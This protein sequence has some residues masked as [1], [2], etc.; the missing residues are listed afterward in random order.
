MIVDDEQLSRSIVNHFIE[1]TN[2]LKL[3]HECKDAIEALN[4]LQE[5][6]SD[7]DLIYLDIQMPEMS[8]MDFMRSLEN[9]IDV[10]I[11]TSG[12]QYAVEAFESSVIDYLVKPFDYGRF[13]RASNKVR[14]RIESLNLRN[15]RRS[16]IYVKSDSKTVRI[17]FKDIFYIEALADYVIFVTIKGKFIVHYTMKGIEQRLPASI[18]SRVHRSFIINKDRIESIED[19]N[20]IMGD[21]AIP[22]G[23]SYRD[24]FISQLNFL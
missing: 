15:E 5:K 21:K 1:K 16:D 10:I 9:P 6:N 24:A 17:M 20:I 13:L 2:F 4:I 3:Q 7:I 18:F 12:E 23:A 11:T 14:S 19:F 22:V 8:G